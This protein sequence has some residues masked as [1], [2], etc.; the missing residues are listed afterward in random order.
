MEFSHKSVLLNECIE[1]LDIKPN[2]IYVD[3]TAGGAGHSSEIAKRLKDGILYALDRDPDAVKVATERLREL[4]AKVIQT[5]F[6]D[7]KDS[8]NTLDKSLT[9]LRNVVNDGLANMSK[10][11]SDNATSVSKALSTMM[12][13][14]IKEVSS[15]TID[16]KF[17]K[18][19]KDWVK[20]L[21]SGVKDQ[22]QKLIDALETLVE[23][24]LNALKTKDNYNK[25]YETGSYFAGGLAKG[26]EDNGAAAVSAAEAIASAVNKAIKGAWLINSP[27]KEAYADGEFYVAGIVNA[28]VDGTQDAFS[29]GKGLA[30]MATAGMRGALAKVTDLIEN[31][32][33]TQPTIKPVLDL[34]DITNKVGVMNGMLTMSPS[35]GVL[36]KVNSISSSMNKNQN[37]Q[38]DD[39][40]S[41]INSL[42]NKLDNAS[43][44]T[45]N[46]NGVT[47]DDGSQLQEAIE[48]IIRA[49]NIERR[50]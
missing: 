43:G 46:I 1:A 17:E 49:A 47:Y 9:N 2:G 32:I 24:A 44:D 23:K 25:F 37:G 8:I 36:A 26:I 34:S 40:V 41:A 28:L 5:N 33:D 12:E 10:E 3:G 42:S 30:E 7:M 20:K 31:G 15:T 27:S 38:N 39:V 48:L 6:K 29:A 19:G 13:G 11:F 18:A 21:K 35:V 50:K 14:L 45:Y 16:K 22:K 4:P